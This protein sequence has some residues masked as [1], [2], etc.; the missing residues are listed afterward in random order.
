MSNKSGPS[1]KSSLEFAVQLRHR[2][3]WFIFLAAAWHRAPRQFARQRFSQV[4][5]GGALDRTRSAPGPAP[6]VRTHIA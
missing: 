1:G 2:A 3:A 4:G 5:S 6:L